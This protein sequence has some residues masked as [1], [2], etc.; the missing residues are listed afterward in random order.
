MWK[1]WF[2]HR[3]PCLIN[4]NLAISLHDEKFFSRCLSENLHILVFSI[5]LHIL[6]FSMYRTFTFTNW[7]YSLLVTIFI[8]SRI[9]WDQAVTSVHTVENLN[10]SKFIS[11][12]CKQ[13]T[14]IGLYVCTVVVGIHIYT[15][16]HEISASFEFAYF[17]CRENL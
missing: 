1:I 13:F 2:L 3:L 11:E 7:F 12:S 16:Q 10:I 9:P 6:A 15:C 17:I 4:S 14:N 8:R 5:N